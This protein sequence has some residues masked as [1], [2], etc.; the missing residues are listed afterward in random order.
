MKC[1]V[2]IIP[3]TAVLI[4]TLLEPDNRLKGVGSG[5]LLLID[6]RLFETIQFLNTL[7]YPCH[8][9]VLIRVQRQVCQSQV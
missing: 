7:F 6:L 3:V 2:L 8:R 9:L 4:V 5:K 1:I